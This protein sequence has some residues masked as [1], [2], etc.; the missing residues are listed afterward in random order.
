M[1]IYLYVK[2]HNITGLK[3]LGKTIKQDPHKYTGSGKYWLRHLQQHGYNYTTEIIRECQSEEELIFWGLHYSNLWN[4]V[5]SNNWANLKEEAGDGGKLSSESRKKISEANRKRK[6]SIETKI[7]MS[8]ADRSSYKRTSPVSDLTKEKLANLLKG[9]PGRA[10]GIKWSPEQKA[11]QSA[12]KKGQ[13]CP[14]KG[15]KRVYR[16]D[17]SFYFDNSTSNACKA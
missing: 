17:G 11:A 8:N 1:T 13:P 15:K 7:K 12:R 4:V 14:T 10:S 3:Y 2:T 9:K 16:E 5:E 6:H